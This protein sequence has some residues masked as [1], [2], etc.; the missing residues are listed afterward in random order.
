[1]DRPK[2]TESTEVNMFKEMCASQE[3]GGT[4]TK[5]YVNYEVQIN[6]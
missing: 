2:H 1:L 5:M 6:N 3:T 4:R